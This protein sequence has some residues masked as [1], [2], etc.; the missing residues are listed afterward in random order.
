MNNSEVDWL[1]LLHPTRQQPL[2]Y[3][4]PTV[5]Q[6]G[7]SFHLYKYAR[8]PPLRFDLARAGTKKGD[9][10]HL[11]DFSCLA[12]IIVSDDIPYCFVNYAVGSRVTARVSLTLLYVAC[13][14]TLY[15]T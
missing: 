2:T 13:Y 15:K 3:S 9:T 8:C 12:R 4:M 1:V 10:A 11:R 14:H 7:Q 6:A 5:K